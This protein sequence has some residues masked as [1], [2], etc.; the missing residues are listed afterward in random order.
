[1][2][3]SGVAV[4][5]AVG[6]LLMRIGSTRK[7]LLGPPPSAD[8]QLLYAWCK[9]RT[10]SEDAFVL[11][12]IL[13]GFR[14]GAQRAVVVDWKCMPIL[15]EDTVE[16]YRRLAAVCGGEFASLGEASAGYTELDTARAALIAHRYHA[17]YVI[18]YDAQ[19][20]GD[21]SA[22]A[23]VY[24]NPTFA[25]YDVTPLQRLDEAVVDAGDDCGEH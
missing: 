18:T 23:C 12:P 22:L 6:V 19:H 4:P 13:G 5:L 24:R 3:A 9:G 11:P 8:E 2:L 16:W 1:M 17:R 10:A 15:P 25:V 7:D 20:E 14:L 21:L